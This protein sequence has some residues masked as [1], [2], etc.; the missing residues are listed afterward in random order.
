MKYARSFVVGPVVFVLMLLPVA[1]VQAQ[2]LCE[3]DSGTLGS[4]R[5]WQVLNHD[6][7]EYK[8]NFINAVVSEKAVWGEHPFT[9]RLV[10][11]VDPRG[12]NSSRFH[13]EGLGDDYDGAEFRL[14][15]AVMATLSRYRQGSSLYPEED[16]VG[17]KASI[18]RLQEAMQGGEQVVI[19]IKRKQPRGGEP[20]YGVTFRYTPEALP[21][22]RRAMEEQIARYRRGACSLAEE[23][24]W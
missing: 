10:T 22:A 13:M 11:T 19:R 1:G 20:T 12:W 17:S 9:I 4:D 23:P 7:D 5:Y 8:D 16:F 2:P 3:V 24:M 15:G 18:K 6:P 14:G 21:A